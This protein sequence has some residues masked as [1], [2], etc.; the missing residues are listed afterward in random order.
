MLDFTDLVSVIL[1]EQDTQQLP[2]WF[3][4]ILEKYDKLNFSDIKTTNNDGILSDI[5]TKVAG[6]PNVAQQ[7]I[8][9]NI[10]F[11]GIYDLLRRLYTETADKS[12]AKTWNDF[13]AQ[14]ISGPNVKRYEEICNNDWNLIQNLTEETKDNWPIQNVQVKNA[15]DAATKEIASLGEKALEGD[16]TLKNTNVIGAVQEIVNRRIGV[17]T[18]IAKLKNPKTPFTNLIQDI[19]KTPELYL[20]GSKK[21]SSDFQAIDDLYIA[22]LINVALAAKNFYASE[23]SKLKLPQLETSSLNIFNKFVASILKENMPPW[24][25]GPAAIQGKQQTTADK[26]QL[27]KNIAQNRKAIKSSRFNEPP[28]QQK[29]QDQQQIQRIQKQ[30]Y[31]AALND[32]P[33]RINFLMGKPIT[34]KLV[35][36][37]GKE[38]GE[39]QTINSKEYTIGNIMQNQSNEAKKLIEE[40]GK[41]AQYTKNKPGAGQRA[42]ERLAYAGQA[43]DAISAFSGQSLYGGPR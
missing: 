19:F 26:E 25:Q 27:L 41:I 24:M 7:D 22:D 20:S 38:T 36:M 13:K 33:N 3:N 37:Q 29:P 16:G 35:D 15:Y 9:E 8:R 6:K 14:L 1:I 32:I 11:V 43:L 40:L 5:Y 23:I 30:L 28:I 42:K 39:Q 4:R 31:N 18:R 2:I 17:F 10:Q 21:Y 34:Y 12:K